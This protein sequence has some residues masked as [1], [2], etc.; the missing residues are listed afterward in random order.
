MSSAPATLNVRV[1]GSRWTRSDRAQRALVGRSE[2]LQESSRKTHRDVLGVSRIGFHLNHG[3]F[4]ENASVRCLLGERPSGRTL[5]IEECGER[6]HPSGERLSWYA[7]REPALVNAEGLRRAVRN[8][9][10]A[11]ILARHWP[12]GSVQASL[13]QRQRLQQL[14]FPEGITFDGKQFVRIGVIANAFSYLTEVDSSQNNLAS[15]MPASWNQIAA[16]LDQIDRL[17]R[18]A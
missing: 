9:A 11:A 8:V 7:D 3:T 1:S 16:W 15:L 12:K 2:L 4:G 18:A 10:V 13:N 17:R 6:V 5:F 14:F